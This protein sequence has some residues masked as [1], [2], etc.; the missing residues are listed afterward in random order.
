MVRETLLLSYTHHPCTCI[1]TYSLQQCVLV[2]LIAFFR[3]L[4]KCFCALAGGSVNIHQFGAYFGLSVAWVIGKPAVSADDEGG[5]VSDLFSLIGTIFLWVYWPSFNGGALEA[6]SHPQQR[7]LG[8]TIMALL[9]ATVGAFVASSYLSQTWKIRPVDIQNATLAGG[10]ALGAVCHMTLS[11]ADTLLIGGAAGLA[12]TLAYNRLQGYLDELGLHDTCGIN[13][14]HGIPSLIGGFAS[15]ILAAYKGPLEHDIPD[16]MIHRDQ[17]KHQI[18]SI[19]MTLGVSVLSGL[20][21]GWIMKQLASKDDPKTVYSDAP[22][23]EIMDDFGRSL[24]TEMEKNMS[25]IEKGLEASKALM[26]IVEEYQQM[27]YQVAPGKMR[28]KSSRQIMV[29]KSPSYDDSL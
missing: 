25:E 19:F 4:I 2:F 26:A 16:V 22:N 14:L 18:L 8:G 5:H 12:S 11:V 28:Q 3:V 1:S 29:Q 15:V 20:A 9:G 6:D 7:A 13:N 27:G 23:W 21:T 24:E 10:V 17:W